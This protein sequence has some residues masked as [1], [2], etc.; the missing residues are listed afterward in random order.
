M[1][2]QPVRLSAANTV[3]TERMR[4]FVEFMTTSL[5]DSDLDIE[6]NALFSSLDRLNIPELNA[7][8]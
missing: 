4:N 3:T 8:L 1:E 7:F 5:L 2:P 6:R